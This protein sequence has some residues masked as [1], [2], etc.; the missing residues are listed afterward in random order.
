MADSHSSREERHRDPVSGGNT[1]PRQG[2]GQR[3]QPAPDLDSILN[4]FAHALGIA[5][6]AHRALR[7]S[8]ED[9]QPLP[10]SAAIFTLA[11]G[12]SR[13]R[14]VL[15]LLG[16]L[17]VRDVEAD[18]RH[19]DARPSG[20][21]FSPSGETAEARLY[22]Y[23]EMEVRNLMRASAV[24]DTMTSLLDDIEFRAESVGEYDPAFSD[25]ARVVRDLIAET[26]KR[27]DRIET[28]PLIDVLRA[29]PGKEPGGNKQKNVHP[30]NVRIDDS[31]NA[32][33]SFLGP[34]PP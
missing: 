18:W 20:R 13:L 27:L 30:E 26:I 5:E 32:E 16:T 12:I 25:V 17:N 11:A 6:T 15:S 7:A 31:G 9:L 1:G 22:H 3:P 4:S 19:T 10:D 24:L 29:K 33:E 2:Q 14:R 8:E 23:I 21:S 34:I 28:G